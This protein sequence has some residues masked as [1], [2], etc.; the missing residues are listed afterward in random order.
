MSDNLSFADTIIPKSDQLNADD[1]VAGPATCTIVKVTRGSDEQPMMVHLDAYPG[2][3]FKPCKGMR[4]VLLAL[5][6]DTASTWGGRRIRIYRNEDVKWGGENVGGIRISGMSD[7]PSGCVVPVTVSRGKKEKQRVDKLDR[8]VATNGPRPAVSVLRTAIG[9]AM[10]ARKWTRDDIR[11]LL[12]HDKA[13]DVHESEHARIIEALKGDPP[14]GP[15]VFDMT[16]NDAITAALNRGV[17]SADIEA[18]VGDRDP[19]TIPDAEAPAIVAKL[20]ALPT[21]TEAD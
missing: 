16:V 10:K 11:V 4:R 8:A 3:P 6:G 18:V 1:L 13:E 15:P 5:W 9:D 7:I 2:R 14:E 21:S 19:K 12:G 17:P 20:A